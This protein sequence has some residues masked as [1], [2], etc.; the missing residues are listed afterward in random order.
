MCSHDWKSIANNDKIFMYSKHR[1]R[2][3]VKFS[4]YLLI[5][6][7]EWNQNER[8]KNILLN[9]ISFVIAL[10]IF[11]FV[12]N[13]RFL[14]RRLPF[15]IFIFF[16]EFLFYGISQIENKNQFNIEAIDFWIRN[17]MKWHFEANQL[18]NQLE[19]FDSIEQIESIWIQMSDRSSLSLS[20]LCVC[21]GR[22]VNLWI[23]VV[24][25]LN[26]IHWIKIKSPKLKEWAREPAINI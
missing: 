24:W 26:E 22:C 13:I 8:R 17:E 18:S 15:I 14:L 9:F 16:I 25:M 21:L 23:C 11:A 10:N 7:K 19:E 6:Q 5:R 20:L 2:K 1:L 4:M 3:S 12:F